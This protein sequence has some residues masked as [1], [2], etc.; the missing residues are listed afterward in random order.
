M[1]DLALWSRLTGLRVL[2]RAPLTSAVILI[3]LALGSGSSAAI[4][5]IVSAVL[6]R[7]LPIPD[8]ERAVIVWMSNPSTGFPRYYMSASDFRDL[9]TGT[10]VFEDIGI[11]GYGTVNFTGGGTRPEALSAVWVMPGVLR[12]VGARTSAGRLFAAG[13]GDPGRSNVVIISNGLWQ[14]SFGSDPRMVGR[15]IILNRVAHT[16]VGVAAPD[17]RGPPVF[18]TGGTLTPITQDV[19]IPIGPDTGTIGGQ[20]LTPRTAR[21]FQVIGRL[22]RGVLASVSQPVSAVAARLAHD[23]PE[24]NKG[25]GMR[26][27]RLD[28][29][30]TSSVSTA[31]WLLLVA[32]VGLHLVA[33]VNVANVLVFQARVREGEM[34]LRMALGAGRARIF[35]LLCGEGLVYSAWGGAAGIGVASAL[36]KVAI[37]ISPPGIPRIN[38][39]TLDARVLVFAV[40]AASLAAVLFALWPSRLAVGASLS[41]RLAGAGRGGSRAGLTQ[42]GLVAFQFAVALLLLVCSGLLGKSL[43]GLT[44]T[45][46]GFQPE[47]ATSTGFFLPAAEY[48]KPEN[49]ERFVRTLTNDLSRTNG[50]DS[51]GVI[52]FLPFS[53]EE[54]RRTFEIEGHGRGEGSEQAHANY[55]R[56]SAGLFRALG[57]GLRQG[58]FFTERDSASSKPVVVV[59]RTFERQHLGGGNP[60]G[61]RVSF[62]P[63]SAQP[64][65]REV[66]GVVEDIK[67]FGLADPPFPDA[68]IPFP[69]E[70]AAMFALIVR[71]KPDSGALAP[72][73]REA[74]LRLDPDRPTGDTISM[75]DLIDRS[76]SRERFYLRLLGM[77]AVSALVLALV[78]V[79]GIAAHQVA[80]RTREIGIRM[81]LGDTPAGVLWSI[82]GPSLRIAVAGS[83]LGLIA[84][85]VLVSRSAHLFVGVSPADPAI[86]CVSVAILVAAAALGS[87]FPARRATEIDPA[88]AM[89]AE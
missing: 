32:A 69:Q 73:I 12:M 21:Y 74:T 45:G 56:V 83:A 49:V 4:F 25:W 2:A 11:Y 46:P 85:L 15:S 67:H 13:E 89:R 86:L 71:A 8:P 38:E 57:I 61:R 18:D 47:R 6:I 79:F 35:R 82:V 87:Y 81:A 44:S 40:A 60:I 84:E 48:P 31:L 64:V 54:Y 33:C 14:R 52:D 16:V 7:P 29:E 80:R 66:V 5:S 75:A 58:R 41:R 24:S 3:A 59:N 20:D 42:D 65:W 10:D 55:R 50:V 22:R 53:G 62:E 39:A 9:R 36:L 37:A 17:F 88:V 26:V 34:A 30:M 72:A 63:P 77:F 68:Y 70:P 28:E 27:A 1:T 76:M 43:I 51:C 19:W 78:G 23:Y